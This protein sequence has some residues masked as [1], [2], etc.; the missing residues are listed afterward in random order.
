MTKRL[1]T[2]LIIVFVSSF[3]KAQGEDHHMVKRSFLIIKSTKN[4]QRALKTAQLACNNLGLT[5][6]LRNNYYD[7]E[8]GLANSE[9]CGCGEMHGYFP[10]GRYDDGNYISIDY[11][12]AYTGF[13]EGY[14]IVIVSSGNR[15]DVKKLLPKA[16]KFYSDAYIKDSKIYMGCMH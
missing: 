13:A 3:G 7:K 9:I 14:Y 1:F 11:S 6:E 10:R 16:Q 4:Y 12:S 8:E 15:E 2:L 5:L